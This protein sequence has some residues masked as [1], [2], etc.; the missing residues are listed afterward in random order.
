V[1]KKIMGVTGVA[2]VQS[3][4]DARPH[5]HW[6]TAVTSS[7]VCKAFFTATVTWEYIL[8]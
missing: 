6:A 4:G 3:G 7:G 2:P 1:N 8:G 5:K